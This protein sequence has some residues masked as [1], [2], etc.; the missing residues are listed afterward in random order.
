MPSPGPPTSSISTAF[1]VA[2][3][4]CDRSWGGFTTTVRARTS[5]RAVRAARWGVAL[6]SRVRVVRRWEA[7]TSSRTL[8][9]A[10]GPAA[11]SRSDVQRSPRAN[12]AIGPRTRILLGFDVDVANIRL[13]IRDADNAR[14]RR[15]GRHL[16]RQSIAFEPAKTFLGFDRQSAAVA[17]FSERFRSSI[18]VVHPQHTE[19]P[20]VGRHRQMRRG[21][22]P[23]PLGR[24]RAP[25]VLGRMLGEVEFARILDEQHDAMRTHP[26]DRGL[27][28]R[29]Q[30]LLRRDGGIVEGALR[31]NGVAPTATRRVDARL[32]VDGQGFQKALA[33]L[34]QTLVFQVDPAE[35]VGNPIPHRVTPC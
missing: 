10:A 9:N 35:F 16:A 27:A 15:I 20:F 7:L 6:S 5:R 23:Q 22:E 18:E 8:Q 31:R 17:G 14:F 12:R 21:I 26:S 1:S 2:A 24:V 19:N 34:V 13:A 25:R 3:G 29:S 32:G 4:R 28:M 11:K 33:P 30:N